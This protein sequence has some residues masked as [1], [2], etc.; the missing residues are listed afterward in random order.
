MI[1]ESETEFGGLGEGALSSGDGGDFGRRFASGAGGT[2]VGRQCFPIYANVFDGAFEIKA[3]GKADAKG[4]FLGIDLEG[5]VVLIEQDFG[6]LRDAID[7]KMGAGG[8]AFTVVGGGD[9]M[10]FVEWDGV[11]GF[12]AKGEICPTEDDVEAE[13]TV[14]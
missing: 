3:T 9:M 5:F 13:F 6:L 4:D 12:E 14:D 10:P 7:V 11:D 2:F 1:D 8:F